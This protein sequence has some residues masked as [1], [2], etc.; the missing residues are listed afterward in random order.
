[1][2]IRCPRIIVTWAGMSFGSVSVYDLASQRENGI[3][4][5]FEDEQIYFTDMHGDPYIVRDTQ[6]VEI[7][8]DIP[9]PS[10]DKLISIRRITLDN[11]ITHSPAFIIP[12]E[13]YGE[14]GVPPIFNRKDEQL[15]FVAEEGVYTTMD[16]NV[17]LISL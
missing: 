8:L 11:E 17:L 16:S 2:I 9:A 15:A 5:I 12:P 13:L 4:N 6:V 1:M 3:P 10:K 7:L 14:Y